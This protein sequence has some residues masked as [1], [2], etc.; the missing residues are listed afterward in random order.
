VPLG[1]DRAAAIE[2]TRIPMPTPAAVRVKAQ[3]LLEPLVGARRL[4]VGQIGGDCGRRLLD[5]A[6]AFDRM[7]AHEAADLGDAVHVDARRDVDSTS[8]ANGVP[9]PAAS[10]AAIPPSDAPTTTGGLPVSSAMARA[11]TSTSAAKS[12]K[13]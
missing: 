3:V 6:E 13:A 11:R 2:K 7:G 12:S 10:N 4:A 1:A 9:C 5:R 8:A